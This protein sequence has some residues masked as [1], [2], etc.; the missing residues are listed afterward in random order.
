MTDAT[1]TRTV[2][3]DDHPYFVASRICANDSR[4]SWEAR[5]ML[6][7]LLSQPDDWQI[8]PEALVKQ[9]PDA[10]REKVYRILNELELAG[11]ISRRQE[12]DSSGRMGPMT[13]RLAEAPAHLDDFD[14][15]ILKR[16]RPCPPS[17]YAEKPDT[18]QPD[19]AKPEHT[20]YRLK[21]SNNH[22]QPPAQ[23]NT[24]EPTPPV[25]PDRPVTADAVGGGGEVKQP[26]PPRFTP[27]EREA[28]AWLASPHVGVG[29]VDRAT[30]DELCHYPLDALKARWTSI[31]TD[32][33]GRTRRPLL[34]GRF[35]QSCR[36][37]PPHAAPPPAPAEPALSPDVAHARAL[38]MQ[39]LGQQQQPRAA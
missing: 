17:P 27:E 9:A 6:S 30:Q 22:H 8:W 3:D 35:V 39:R 2:H 14:R 26:E 15:S 18:A 32:D 38:L 20:K 12:R 11:Y 23:P 28:R 10:G 4:L 1:I 21:P 31:L 13:T 16:S 37:D 25:A 34:I 36:S 24:P 7:Y 5:G 33:G 19:T 29:V